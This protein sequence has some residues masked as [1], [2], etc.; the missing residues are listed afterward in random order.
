MHEPQGAPRSSTVP[1]TTMPA[2]VFTV[3]I[4]G[5]RSL[6][7]AIVEA[8]T[9]RVRTVMEQ[10]SAQLPDRAAASA[11]DRD[12]PI[13]MRFLTALAAGADQLPVRVFEDTAPQAPDTTSAWQLHTIL[14]FEANAYRATLADGLS[15]DAGARAKVLFDTGLARAA[16]TFEIC[17]QGGSGASETMAHWRD[18]RFR[19]LGQM[20]VRQADLVVAIWDGDPP[21]GVGGTADVVQEAVRVGVPLIWIDSRDLSTHAI[22]DKPVGASIIAEVQKVRAGVATLPPAEVAITAAIGT[23]L[24]PGADAVQGEEQVSQRLDGLAKLTGAGGKGLRDAK[25]QVRLWVFYQW[26][27]DLLVLRMPRF[28]VATTHQ[29]QAHDQQVAAGG[30]VAGTS[31][32]ARDFAVIDMVATYGG[33]RYRSVYVTIFFGTVLAVFLGLGGLVLG[34]ELKP[35]LILAELL[36]LLL[37]ASLFLLAR[38]RSWHRRWLNA[39]H[40]A[41]S[42]RGNL[43]LAGMGFCG[44]R[45]VFDRQA[46]GA[47][48]HGH[49]TGHDDDWPLWLAN[50]YAAQP[51]IPAARA[52]ARYIESITRVVEAEVGAQIAYH[53]ENAHKLSSAHHALDRAGWAAVGIAAVVA[54]LYLVLF[55]YLHL[56]DAYGPAGKRIKDLVTFCG[57]FLPAVAAALAGIRFQADFERFAERS[58][59]TATQLETLHAR[60]AAILAGLTDQSSAASKVDQPLFEPLLSVIL[61]IQE[62]FEKDLEDWRL[63]YAAR[64]IQGL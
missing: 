15:S 6:A 22:L 34:Q 56:F 21:S 25:P 46:H 29:I 61:S 51:G 23:V 17:D 38:T 57:G 52:D 9:A 55:E 36:C 16:R 48:R 27:I 53:R 37:L 41:E 14:P 30:G 28:P 11:L 54:L 64:P 47:T 39:R 12:R 24:A 20:L 60:L 35:Q 43:L 32:L 42:L 4:T 59:K 50:A 40:I 44:R 18:L 5:H 10:V 7:D 8:L 19:T 33:H 45:P 49:G 13:E 2:L 1:P 26:L 31:E 3:A 58:H 62:V 63:V